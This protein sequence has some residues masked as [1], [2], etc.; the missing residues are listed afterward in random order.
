MYGV[1]EDGDLS[2]PKGVL[3]RA[4]YSRDDGAVND[5]RVGGSA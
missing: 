3:R 2:K 4:T 1:D 5:A